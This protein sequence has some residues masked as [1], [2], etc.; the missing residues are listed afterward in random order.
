[1][2]PI[3]VLVAA[4]AA[5][6]GPPGYSAVIERFEHQT[7]VHDLPI[8]LSTREIVDLYAALNAQSLQGII[9]VSIVHRSDGRP[10][11]RIVTDRRVGFG[12]VG[13]GADRLFVR[14]R[15]KIDTQRFLELAFIA[16]VLPKFDLQTDVS[17]AD[18]ADVLR[19]MLE[20]FVGSMEKMIATGGLRPTHERVNRVLSNRIRGKLSIP[21]FMASLAKGRP[22]Q[23]PCEFSALVLDNAANRLLKWALA[24]TT[25]MSRELHDDAL[26]QARL[27][28]IERHFRDVS[29]VRPSRTSLERD[30]VLP[31]NQR[32]YA[33]VVR[34]AKMLLLNF[35]V[36]SSPGFLPSLSL[37]MNM[38]EIYERS[39]WNLVA[40]HETDAHSKPAW[41]L[42]F[43]PL[44][45]R[46]SQLS[47]QFE[48]DIFVRGSTGRH[49]MVIDTKW[50]NAVQPYQTES[51]VRPSTSD[52]YQV[53]TYA[54]TV[55][56]DQSTTKK[57]LA[58][59][60][61][62]SLVD[63]T[64]MEHR[65]AV[66]DFETV[67]VVMG[68]NVSRP[69]HEEIKAIWA[70]LESLRSIEPAIIV[71]PKDEGPVRGTMVDVAR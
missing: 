68:W 13:R 21:G 64:P 14:V 53:A 66:G 60:M 65:I 43:N 24:A 45:G 46:A 48:P 67:I 61:Y 1:M 38:H 6:P 19:W 36:D 56:R 22:D 39:F 4:G 9:K 18:F 37:S 54:S 52:I 55:L 51:M 47:V 20:L 8:D 27:A 41:R 44:E 35:H 29:L 31:P 63:C 62:P 42:G 3:D 69:P 40:R 23:I 10:Q 12:S 58:V 15:P 49:P 70:R 50:K 32:H 59:L 30:T 17:V 26:V 34:I 16:G 11:L 33:G 5:Q 7:S 2:A 28:L 57:C 25:K 71:P